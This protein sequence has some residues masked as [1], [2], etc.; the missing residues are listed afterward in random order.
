MR[1]FFS[2]LLVLTVVAN[3]VLVSASA[4]ER[5]TLTL[6]DLSSESQSEKESSD[7]NEEDK[8]LEFLTGE[9]DAPAFVKVQFSS[10]SMS[11]KIFAKSYKMGV[12]SPPPELVIG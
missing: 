11:R 2:I 4:Y 1:I 10:D 8:K 3:E 6:M 5:D 7:S 12:K 9:S